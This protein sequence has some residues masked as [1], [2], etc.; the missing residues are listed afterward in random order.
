MICTNLLHVDSQCHEQN[1]DNDSGFQTEEDMIQNEMK[2]ELQ[3]ND[4][5]DNSMSNDDHYDD[6]ARNDGEDVMELEE[7]DPV[8]QDDD[9]TEDDRGKNQSII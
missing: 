7:E 4:N 6:D 3:A 2:P 8:K 5:D 1:D 9:A